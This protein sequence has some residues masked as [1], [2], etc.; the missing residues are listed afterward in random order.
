M[1]A[2]LNYILMRNNNGSLWVCTSK[3]MRWDETRDKNHFPIKASLS[4]EK[5][6]LWLTLENCISTSPNRTKI[7][8]GGSPKWWER[9]PADPRA[10]CCQ[11]AQQGRYILVFL[12]I[13]LMDCPSSILALIIRF[14]TI[15]SVYCYPEEHMFLFLLDAVAIWWFCLSELLCAGLYNSNS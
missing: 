9:K 5:N 7:W 1:D 10:R 12:C 6:Q 15:F 4:M 3:E 13:V 14:V 11:G 8:D 2:L